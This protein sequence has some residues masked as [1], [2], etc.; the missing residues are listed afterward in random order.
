[1]KIGGRRRNEMIPS[2]C[3]IKCNYPVQT[4]ACNIHCPLVELNKRVDKLRNTIGTQANQIMALQKDVE[5]LCRVLYS[6]MV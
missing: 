4:V 2:E 5:D 1:M 6:T 3:K